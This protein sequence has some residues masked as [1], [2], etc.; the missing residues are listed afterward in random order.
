MSLIR[1]LLLLLLTVHIGLAHSQR[2][3][4]QVLE[5]LRKRYK[6]SFESIYVTDSALNNLSVHLRTQQA[7]DQLTKSGTSTDVLNLLV[8][9]LS[10]ITN[11]RV[12][13]Q[14]EL[15]GLR[16]GYK[17]QSDPSASI[18]QLPWKE[19]QV[20]HIAVLCDR[21]LQGQIKLAMLKK[22]LGADGISVVASWSK[23]D[24]L[25]V[26]PYVPIVTMVDTLT[27]FALY[28]GRHEPQVNALAK[29][30][31][32]AYKGITSFKSYVVDQKPPAG[33]YMATDWPTPIKSQW[34]N[35]YKVLEGYGQSTD[36][37]LV[38]VWRAQL[39][40]LQHIEYSKLLRTMEGTKP[41]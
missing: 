40:G 29:S 28:A 13:L 32:L 16:A 27:A 30:N 23:F 10:D 3:D 8:K 31:P 34:I 37:T 22:Q 14:L 38:P 33:I 11:E 7:Q 17:R 36:K 21:Y 1:Y 9:F 6:Q 41:Q 26:D 24:E 20:F 19:G 39:D 18:Q 2:V 5:E 15:R 12:F 25:R 4:Q 35:R